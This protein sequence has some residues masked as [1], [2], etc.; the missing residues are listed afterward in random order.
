MRQR[1]TDDEIILKL[2]KEG[3][4]QKEISE[5]FNVSP[6]AIHKRVKRLCPPGDATF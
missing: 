5:Y 2:L 6:V 3:K 1:K 4:T